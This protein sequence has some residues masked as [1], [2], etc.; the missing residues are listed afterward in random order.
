MSTCTKEVSMSIEEILVNFQ[1]NLFIMNT[2]TL[3]L[4]VFASFHMDDFNNISI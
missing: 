4:M 1:L 3:K 2:T